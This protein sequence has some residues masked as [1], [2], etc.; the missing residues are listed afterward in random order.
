MVSTGQ[1][2]LAVF[3]IERQLRSVA[4]NNV[5]PI[6]RIY[7]GG[8]M[9]A[10]EGGVLGVVGSIP[11]LSANIVSP[12]GAVVAYQA[13]EYDRIRSENRDMDV[14]AAFNL[15]GVE[16]AWQALID[17][18]QIRTMQGRGLL[19]S[20]GR[21]LGKIQ[22][23]G[24]RRTVGFGARGLEQFGQELFQ[25]IG[26][27]GIDA[28]A[29]AVREDMK[30]Q[31]FA[32]NVGEYWKQA[33]EVLVA[34]LIFGLLGGKAISTRDVKVNRAEL[35]EQARIVGI[36]EDGRKRMQAATTPEELDAVVE[37]EL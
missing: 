33:P 25:D 12:I 7:K 20:T 28:L 14:R 21:L 26:T 31:N 36:G 22:S 35:D 4:D 15:A 17:R 32:L 11:I 6:K 23:T 27:M 10:L 29:A 9:G 8:V 37:R 2:A 16:G 34:S 5:D 1:Q 3:R 30:D 19:P 24:L 13:M 18:L